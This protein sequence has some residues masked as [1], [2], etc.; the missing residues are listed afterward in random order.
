[1]GGAV[2]NRLWYHP[3]IGVKMIQ[4]ISR[5]SGTNKTNSGYFMLI[6]KFLVQ[7]IFKSDK[8]KT[9]N[10]KILYFHTF[11]PACVHGPLNSALHS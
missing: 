3:N 4:I 6:I 11:I 8:F 7:R 10:K 2:K 1:M 9:A 5:T